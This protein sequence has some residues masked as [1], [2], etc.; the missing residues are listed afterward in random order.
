MQYIA[1]AIHFCILAM[2]LITPFAMPFLLRRKG[3][4]ASLLLSSFLSFIACVLLVSLFAY[5]PHLYASLRLDYLGFDFDGWSDEDRARNI[6]PELRDEATKLYWSTMGI[7]WTF[8]AIVGAVLLIP[9]QI[10]A[11]GLVFMA[12]KLKKRGKIT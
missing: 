5:L 6:S 3:Y 2:M 1:S 4:V 8:Q 7:G 12:S 9:Y 11:S 10:V